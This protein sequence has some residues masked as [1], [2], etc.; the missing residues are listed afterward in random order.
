MQMRRHPRLA[1]KAAP[2]PETVVSTG[3]IKVEKTRRSVITYSPD[4]FDEQTVDAVDDCAP[5]RNATSPTWLRIIGLHE[6]DS[7]QK[8]GECL[9]LHPMVIEDLLDTTQRSKIEFFDDYIFIVARVFKAEKESLGV[10]AEQVGMVVFDNLVVTFEEGG[11]D[12]FSPVKERLR[13]SKG[14]G[15]QM[16]ADYLVYSLLDAIV[17][18]Y[19]EI[20]EE[21]GER[22]EDLEE[23]IVTDP[24]AEALQGVHELRTDISYIRRC[25]WPLREVMSSLE[26]GET[27]LIS[28]A[29]TVYL[30]DVYDHTI[31]LIDAIET[32]QEIVSNLVDIYLSGVSNR[33]NEIMKRLTVVATIF[34]PLTFLVGVYGMN[35]KSMPEYNWTWAYPALWGLMVTTAVAQVAYFRKRGW[36]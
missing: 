32:Y 28:E 4:H 3:D 36:L 5:L 20:I 29:V 19:F 25:V 24:K 31:Q 11:V 15:R 18:A 8:L 14:R 9:G 35:L 22:L 7:L 26:R 27:T 13:T 2:P 16:G 33:M 23:S 21:I 34:I 10:D 6:T 17:D 12:V 1:A 30:R